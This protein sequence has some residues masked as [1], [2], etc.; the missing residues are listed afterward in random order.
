[1]LV[2]FLKHCRGIITAPSHAK[3][4][5]QYSTTRLSVR[6]CCLCLRHTGD[7]LHTQPL[8]R[9]RLTTSNNRPQRQNYFL[10]YNKPPPTQI[11]GGGGRTPSSKS[12]SKCGNTDELQ[13]ASFHCFPSPTRLSFIICFLLMCLFS[14]FIPSLLLQRLIALCAFSKRA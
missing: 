12:M 8:A 7:R 2:M 4:K 13:N 9:W 3:L 1:M 11:G 14:I 6:L 10:S 5:V